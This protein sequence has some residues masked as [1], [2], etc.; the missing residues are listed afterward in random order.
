MGLSPNM[1]FALSMLTTC[2]RSMPVL[3]PPGGGDTPYNGLYGE[4]SAERVSFSGFR[5][6][7][8]RDFTSWSILRKG[9]DICHLGPWKGPEG[10]TGEFYG[11]IKSMQSSNQ[12]MSTTSILNRRCTKG[13]TKRGISGI[14]PRGRTSRYKTLSKTPPVFTPGFFF[15]FCSDDLISHLAVSDEIALPRGVELIFLKFQL[16]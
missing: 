7:K 3:S 14:G 12:G 8:S 9:R 5:Y 13:V 15:L 2:S 11:F 4:A 6:M 10:L 16:Y 1:M